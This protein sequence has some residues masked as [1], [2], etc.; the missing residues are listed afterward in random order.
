[1]DVTY[2]HSQPLPHSP[3]FP[4]FTYLQSLNK[5]TEQHREYRN[6]IIEAYVPFA[7]K[8]VARFRKSGRDNEEL[9]QIGVVGLIKAVDRFNPELSVPFKAFAHI[10][11]TGEVKRFV[12]DSSW[13]V[14]VPR[15]WKDLS[16]ALFSAR[17]QL[18][19]ELGREPSR[20][21]MAKKIGCSERDLEEAEIAS[22]G[23]AGVASI[24]E[25]GPSADIIAWS[26]TSNRGMFE[27]KGYNQIETRDALQWA[28]SFLSDRER[29]MISLRFSEELTQQEIGERLGISQMQVSRSLKRVSCKMRAVLAD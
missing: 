22:Q 27:E 26:K 25:C 5:G 14:H 19:T 6:R 3:E 12:R 20:Q 18:S 21:E 29:L 28:M 7:K 24:E 16:L 10:Y 17:E 8:S 15:K 2:D 23:R 9:I 11:I 4:S 1:M 13:G